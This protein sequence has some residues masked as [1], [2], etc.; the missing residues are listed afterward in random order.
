M[1]LTDMPIR[2]DCG[3]TLGGGG[4]HD[5]RAP[6]SEGCARRLEVPRDKRAKSPAAARE[7][8]GYCA[9]PSEGPKHRPVEGRTQG[10]D[11]G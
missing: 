1:A 11:T 7:S 3:K 4:R 6:G 2:V 10:L 9:A 5:V 8:W